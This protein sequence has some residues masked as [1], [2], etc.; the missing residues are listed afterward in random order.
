MPPDLILAPVPTSVAG[1]FDADT[2]RVVLA[3]DHT[4]M[5]RNLKRLLD[6]ED[7][8]TVVAE[9]VD[10]ETAARRA[11]SHLPDVLILDLHLPAGSAVGLVAEL[12]DS[13]PETQVVV[14]TM[15][16]SPAFVKRALD[17]GAV[18]Y[19]LK[20][21]ADRDLVPAVRAALGGESYVTPEVAEGLEARRTPDSSSASARRWSVTL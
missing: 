6:A 4:A 3:D 16:N 10:L 14:L 17:A 2:I 18:G 5:R 12:R 21:H 20:E 11:H 13:L 9:A 15:E 19:V 8:V 1:A 7:G